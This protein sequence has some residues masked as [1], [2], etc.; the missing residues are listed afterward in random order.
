M[1]RS[2]RNCRDHLFH[3]TQFICKEAELRKSDLLK[4]TQWFRL[5][6]WEEL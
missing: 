2:R 5:A 4:V 3:M 6:V 1:A